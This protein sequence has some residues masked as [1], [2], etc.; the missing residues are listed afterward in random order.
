MPIG[1][2]LCASC[3]RF[4]A[5]ITDKNVCEAFPNGIPDVVFFGEVDHRNPVKGDNGLQY[6]PDGSPESGVE[7]GQRRNLPFSN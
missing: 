4:D 5:S 1:A 2:S 3:T 6:L 7:N